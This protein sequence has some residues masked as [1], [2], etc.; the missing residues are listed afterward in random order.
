MDMELQR[1]RLGGFR[2]VYDG[3]LRQEETLESIV[4]DALPDIDRIV[5]AQGSVLLRQKEVVDGSVRVMGSV[6]LNVLYLPEGGGGLCSIALNI[7]FLCS[8][9]NPAIRSGGQA[10][11][12]ASVISA[13]A[14]ALNPRKVLARAEMSIGLCVFEE[15]DEEITTGVE[16]GADSLETL[17]ERYQDY[18]T[19]DVTEK[20]FTFHDTVR[21]PAS[22]PVPQE[23]LAVRAGLAC[24]ESKIIGKKLVVKGE[25]VLDL[26]YRSEEGVSAAAVELPFSQIAETKA[27]GEDGQVE[28]SAVLTGLDC[29]LTEDG[30]LEVNVEALLEA[31][32]RQERE[33][34]LLSDLYSTCQALDTQRQQVTLTK[35]G[36]QGSRRQI[37]RQF[38]PTDT[39]AQRVID[40]GLTMGEAAAA[41]A[42]EGGCMATAR[43]YVDILYAGE[44]GSLHAAAFAIPASCALPAPRG[45]RC[46]CAPVGEVSAM[47]VTGGL[48]VRFETEFSYLSVEPLPAGCVCAV[49]PGQQEGYEGRRPSVIL[50]MPGQGERL[51]DVAKCCGSTVADIKAANG[52]TGED[53]QGTLLLVPSRR[54]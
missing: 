22:K 36:E 44:D 47:P 51:W 30:A 33:V 25:A 12:T 37:T 35:L 3:A 42:G 9:D 39:A 11:V 49:T 6:R 19:A 31:A 15:A 24:G 4:P 52:L 14:R 54:P 40:C 17:V 18:G 10:Q 20:Y 27:V 34:A 38:C 41:P 7:P 1:V 8:G 13:D 29:T 45:C 26:V 5:T 53:V 21:L 16:R 32:V 23:L 46:R 50:R 2:P 48:E 43:A 28:C